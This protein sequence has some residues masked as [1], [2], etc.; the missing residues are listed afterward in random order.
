MNTRFLSP[1][2]GAISG[3]IGSVA[4]AALWM[5][6][7]YQDGDWVLGG[8]TLSELGDRSRSGAMLFNG[9]VIIAG[10]MSLLFAVGLYRLLSTSKLGKLGAGTLGLASVFLIGIGLFPIDTG[11]PHTTASL[12][13]F[14]L[15]GAAMAL[16][17]VPVWR[18]HVLNRGGGALTAIVLLTAIAGV[19]TLPLPAA[20]ALAVGCVLLWTV[21]ISIRM[22]WHHRAP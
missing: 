6:A 22:L 15:G 14:V 9:G 7:A 13:F 2:V 18:S 19:M 10:V 20:E 11:S 17:I 1:R 12:G 16:L 8:M 5:A 21:L 4:F 3:I